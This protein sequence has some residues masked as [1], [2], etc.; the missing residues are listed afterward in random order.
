MPPYAVKVGH[1]SKIAHFYL[2]VIKRIFP[3]YNLHTNWYAG[4]LALS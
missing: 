3:R 2:I 1:F 4:Q